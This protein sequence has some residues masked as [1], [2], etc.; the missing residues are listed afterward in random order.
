MMPTKPSAL[1]LTSESHVCVAQRPVG[2]REAFVGT[3]VIHLPEARNAYHSEVFDPGRYSKSGDVVVALCLPVGL[4]C[5]LSEA[6]LQRSASS[7]S[8]E[9]P[10]VDVSGVTLFH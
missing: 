9:D 10:F 3:C 5:P 8:E 2:A 1:R 6:S 4:I 7:E